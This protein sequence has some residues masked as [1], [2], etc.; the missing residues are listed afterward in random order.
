MFSYV[1]ETE[2]RFYLANEVRQ[3]VRN[4]GG[5]T[6]FEL[7]LRDAWVWDMYRTSRF[8]QSRAGRHVQGRQHRGAPGQ[9]AVG[10]RTRRPP[11][12]SPAAGSAGEDRAADWYRAAGYEVL[13]RNWRCAEGE[14]DLVVARPGELVF[15]EV[16]TRTSDR[17]GLPAEA[18]TA[19]KQ[20]RLRLLAARFLAEHPLGRRLGG[21][22]SPLRR[23]GR[24]RVC[25]R[26]DPGGVLTAGRVGSGRRRQGRGQ[27]TSGG[28]N[29]QCRRHHH[30]VGR[31]TAARAKRVEAHR[32][33]IVPGMGH[34]QVERS[35]GVVTVTL[36]QALEAE[37]KAQTDNVGTKD[38]PTRCPLSS[39]A[40]NTHRMGLELGCVF[41]GVTASWMA[42]V[43]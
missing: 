20:R 35:Q 21:E 7:E 32:L 14:L 1:V 33:S 34:V 19:A 43:P 23:G 27:M 15:C 8:V 38:T 18:V 16:K 31:R 30:V 26:G 29:D 5:R 37:A 40:G 42:F 4:E 6:Y 9:G 25:R 39:K 41:G 22:E 10:G 11:A 24:D 17:F 2:R 3:T 36:A 13:A 12:L 28:A